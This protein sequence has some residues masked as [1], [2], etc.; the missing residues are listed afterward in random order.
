MNLADYAKPTNR[1]QPFTVCGVPKCG[2]PHKSLNLCVNHYVAYWKQRKTA[3]FTR[4]TMSTTE[5]QKVV[6]LFDLYG[7][8]GESCGVSECG[9]AKHAKNLCVNHYARYN[10]FTKG[11]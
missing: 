5:L 3:G 4:S 8:A 10:R 1:H 2:K 6:A 7:P 9:K 11:K